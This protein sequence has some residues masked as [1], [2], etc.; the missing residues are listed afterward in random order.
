MKERFFMPVSRAE[1]ATN[2]NESHAGKKLPRLTA[3]MDNCGAFVNF[4][5]MHCIVTAG[6]TYEPLDEVRRLTNFSSGKLGS[7]LADFLVARGH[8][9]TL[10]YGHYATYREKQTAQN[11][12]PF[13]TTENLREKL[14][15]FGSQNIGAVFHVAAVSDFGFG[16]VWERDAAGELRELKSGKISSRAGTLLAELVST[17]KIIASL[18]GYFAKSCLVGWKYEIDGGQNGVLDKA[19]K[20]IRENDTDACV[21]NGNAYGDGFGLIHRD[22]TQAHL[23]N[24][25]EL[26]TALEELA[27]RKNL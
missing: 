16:K 21:A 26:F 24:A 14:A 15:S 18:R 27:L 7:Q 12:L 5:I 3:I 23:S 9:V 8:E 1:C 4:P 10:L 25:M 6:P 11:I 19:R 17:P 2:K 20:Q 13:D 22:G